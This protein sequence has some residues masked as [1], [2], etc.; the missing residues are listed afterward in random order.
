[1]RDYQKEFQKRVEFIK[2][3]L[4]KSEASGIVF[5]NSGGKDSALAGI[6][7]KAACNDMVIIKRL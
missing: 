4:K 2:D 1:M 7:C 5:G 6:L 3:V